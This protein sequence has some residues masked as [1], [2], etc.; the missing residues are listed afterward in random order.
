MWQQFYTRLM[1]PVS[2]KE[3]TQ[4][5]LHL[6]SAR[7]LSVTEIKLLT[8]GTWR[9]PGCECWM[10]MT[11]FVFSSMIMMCLS[12]FPLESVRLHVKR[13]LRHTCR[14]LFS[15]LLTAASSQT[16]Q[17]GIDW[18]IPLWSPLCSPSELSPFLPASVLPL[19]ESAEPRPF[20]TSIF[21]F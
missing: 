21:G 10:L 14:C 3:L 2:N 20:I 19:L 11:F 5:V 9:H 15:C 4:D 6:H 13:R 12:V 18:E 17:Q 1:S 16:V 7:K 8:L